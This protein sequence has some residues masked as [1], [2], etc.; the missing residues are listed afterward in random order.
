MTKGY[1]EKWSHELRLS[2]PQDLPVKGTVG[3]FIQRQLHDIW[4]QYVMPGYGFT[5]PYWQIRQAP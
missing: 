4:E 5:N 1:F 2:T 3:V